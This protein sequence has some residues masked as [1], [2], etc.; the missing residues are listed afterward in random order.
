MFTWHFSDHQTITWPSLDP[1]LALISSFQLK[2]SCPVVVVV[3][4]PITNPTSGSS[5]DVWRWSWPWPWPWAWQYQIFKEA[6]LGRW[7]E[8]TVGVCWSLTAQG[9]FLGIACRQL[10]GGEDGDVLWHGAVDPALR[11]CNPEAHQCHDTRMI[12]WTDLINTF[13]AMS[14]NIAIGGR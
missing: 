11:P 6:K 1:Y 8:F 10:C 13:W 3:D 5:F 7:K 14:C 12:L 9:G 2:K 4:Q